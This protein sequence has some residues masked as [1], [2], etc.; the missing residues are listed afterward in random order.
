MAKLSAG[1]ANHA[2][3]R[4]FDETTDSFNM[5]LVGA[6]DVAVAPSGQTDLQYGETLGLLTSASY[7]VINYTVS[8]ND[9]YVQKIYFS[10]TQVGTA[11]VYKNS[12]ALLKI[13]LSPATYTQ[14]LDLA[15][16]SAFGL[17]LVSGD[18]IKVEV[19]NNS[20]NPADFNITMQLMI[21]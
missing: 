3:V 5:Q 21:T 2:L 18:N 15:T 16:G 10:G 7:N 12:I 11:V 17:R 9:E 4:A 14:V 8:G 6:V 1:D 13:R 19:I 20:N